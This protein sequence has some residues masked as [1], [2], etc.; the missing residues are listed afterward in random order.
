[1]MSLSGVYGE[2]DDAE[3]LDAL[4]AG[5]KAVIPRSASPREI[6]ASIAAAGFQTLQFEQF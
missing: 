2:A 1:M 5:A 6:T 4:V 3:G